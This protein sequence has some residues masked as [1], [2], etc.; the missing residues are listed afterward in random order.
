MGWKIFLQEAAEGVSSWKNTIG[1]AERQKAVRIDG[2]KFEG[3][4]FSC[5][6]NHAWEKKTRE[7]VCN[8]ET[9][10]SG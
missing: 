7:V 1:G 10:I 9:R 6:G 5:C 4:L 2:F 3:K 8:H